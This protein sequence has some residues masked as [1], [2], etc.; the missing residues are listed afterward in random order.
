MV[1]FSCDGCGGILKK[2]QVDAHVYKCRDGCASVSC[3]DCS[4]AFYGDDFRAHTSCVT[5]AERYEKTVYRGPKKNG[6]N[7]NK[8]LSAQEAWV[9]LLSNAGDT[10]PPSI[11]SHVE[12]LSILDNVPRK[13]KQFRNFI[14]NSLRINKT[15]V[16]DIWAHLSA[17][18]EEEKKR[19]EAQATANTP[20]P[21]NPKS[22]PSI[23][24]TA[25]VETAKDG[26]T[27]DKK[28]SASVD[29]EMDSSETEISPK[30]VA[31]TMKK[32]LKK[33]PNRTMKVKEL[34]R[35]IETKILEKK[36][37]RNAVKEQ[38]RIK[39]EL[40]RMILN[41][42]NDCSKQMKIEGNLVTLLK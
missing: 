38:K 24:S 17:L 31:K 12:Q 39:S 18:R 34:R 21:S 1:V 16:D 13:E 9:L 5:E 6:E 32:V 26:D 23:E 15:V 27:V 10:A 20:K 25:V 29:G 11:Q 30:V 40:K 19:R 7:G 14:A 33:A 2:A 36:E 28:D 37:K 22:E 42:I 35:A 41:Q 3:V 8:K 4:V